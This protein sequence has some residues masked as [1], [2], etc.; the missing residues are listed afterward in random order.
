MEA[1]PPFSKVALADSVEDPLETSLLCSNPWLR[2]QLEVALSELPTAG[3]Q[4]TF[5]PTDAPTERSVEAE[6][7][8]E[9]CTSMAD[10]FS[11]ALC[12]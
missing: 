11:K 7:R 4:V 6:T 3:S 1:W 5:G 8:V 12:R 9:S 2:R 10:G